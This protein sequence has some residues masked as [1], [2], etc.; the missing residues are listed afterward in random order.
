MGLAVLSQYFVTER[1]RRGWR[2]TKAA[3]QQGRLGCS[4]VITNFCHR[5][6]EKCLRSSLDKRGRGHWGGAISSL[7]R[8]RVREE[9]LVVIMRWEWERKLGYFSSVTSFTVTQGLLEGVFS[10]L[11]G[12]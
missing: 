7:F 9:G 4:S 3:K 1:A 6:A 2:S 10:E 12:H 8:H 11:G 5:G